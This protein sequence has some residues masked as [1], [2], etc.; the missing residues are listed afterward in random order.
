[1]SEQLTLRGTLEGHEGMITSLACSESNSNMLVSSSRD[2]KVIIWELENDGESCGYAKKSLQGHSH[3]ISDIAISSD[4][5]FIL[6]SSWDHQ[7]RLWSVEHGKSICR[8]VGHTKDVLS[9]AFSSDSRHIVTAGAD[10]TLKLWNTLGQCKYTIEGGESHADWVNMVRFSP[11]QENPLIVSVGSDK[12]L[13]CFSLS[14]CKLV[15]NHIGHTGS[16]NSLCISPDGSLCASAGKG[17]E[18]LLWDLNDF[19][20]L[21]QMDAGCTVNCVV[22]SPNRYWLAA[23]C[24]DG[25]VRVYDL[26]SK[27]L[28]DELIVE[29]AQ[30]KKSSCT[31]LAWAAHGDT[32]YTGHADSKIR[33]FQVIRADRKSVV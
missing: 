8:F 30:G 27:N 4:G 31:S 25:A 18:V 10:K 12:M 16:I 7:S 20:F 6:S 26:E 33:V 2:K 19:K 3:F 29:D 9:C 17:G 1:M 22:F 32:L 11:N 14:N 28:V 21:Y 5:Q 15:S 13:K 23:A 24:E